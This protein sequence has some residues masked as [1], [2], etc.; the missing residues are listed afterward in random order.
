MTNRS[1]FYEKTQ[2]LREYIVASLRENLNAAHDLLRDAEAHGI[3][4]E[5]M[6]AMTLE[7]ARRLRDAETDMKRYLTLNKVE[8]P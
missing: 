4:Q 8:F 3:S 6:H 1:D 5:Q 7:A 2:D